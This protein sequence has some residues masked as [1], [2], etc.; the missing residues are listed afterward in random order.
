MGMR[1]TE[2]AAY[3]GLTDQ[4]YYN[5]SGVIRKK[6][7]L[8]EYKTKLDIFLREKL[9]QLNALLVYIHVEDDEQLS[10]I[11]KRDAELLHMFETP[12]HHYKHNIQ[13]SQNAEILIFL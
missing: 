3:M 12:I 2:I 9:V 5:F 8:M 7:G 10:R 11:E 4:S 6:L 1:G 13:F